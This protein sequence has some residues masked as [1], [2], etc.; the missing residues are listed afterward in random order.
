ML[1]NFLQAFGK[2]NKD[3]FAVSQE[4]IDE[5]NKQLPSN[6]TY[7]QDETG[8]FVIVPK[9]GD[10][11]API[12]IRLT[13]AF[14]ENEDPALMAQLDKIPKDKWLEYLY[15][16]QKSVKVK[17]VRIGDDNKLIALEDTVGDPFMETHAVFRD[18]RLYP[19]QFEDEKIIKL[20]IETSTGEKYVLQLQQ[21]A[22]DSLVEVKYGN[23][24]FP[25]IK[26]EMYVYSPLGEGISDEK[27]VTSEA[28]PMKATYTVKPKKA[29][30]VKE[31]VQSLEVFR[32]L[33][34]GT[35]K[36]DGKT[37]DGEEHADVDLQQI[38]EQLNIWTT[39]LRLEEALN[40]SFIPESEVT[41][42]DDIW[43]SSL[44]TCILDGREL[45]W[46]HPLESFHI[47]SISADETK[48]KIDE[49]LLKKTSR[50][51]FFE[52]PI[53]LLL[54]GAEFTVYCHTI[55][56]GFSVTNIEW[57]DEEH[58]GATIYLADG[59]DKVWTLSRKYMT[60][61]QMQRIY[62]EKQAQQGK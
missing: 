36:S 32:E 45:V 49:M 22:Y 38:E 41:Q 9:V 16:C 11:G 1:G 53:N 28:T 7:I 6:F 48:K 42:A 13:G 60:E 17:N 2:K 39:L 35:L 18:L 15:R 24:N 43:I 55:L 46:Q 20:N 50:M 14:D 52:A 61:S 25:A 37:I 30:T 47:G 40:V 51:E 10:P 57:D 3:D 62:Q 8:R 31:A 56:D 23:V 44:S 34:N 59:A 58:S 27:A 19:G 5:L 54:L 26:I 12:D 21:Q 33:F 4:I 29:K